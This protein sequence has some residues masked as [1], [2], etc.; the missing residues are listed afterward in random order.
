MAKTRFNKTHLSVLK[1]R[2]R[3]QTSLLI[4][5][6]GPPVDITIYVDISRNPGPN[7]LATNSNPKVASNVNLQ[8]NSTIK[9]YTRGELFKLRRASK[10]S[11]PIFVLARMKSANILR[12]WGKRANN[13]FFVSVGVEASHASKSLIELHNLSPPADTTKVPEIIEADKFQ[14]HLVSSHEIHRIIMSYSSNKAPGYDNITMSVIKDAL[15]CILPVLTDI[16][17]Q[18]LLSSAF[19]SDW[20]ISGFTPLLKEGDHE[21]AKNNCPV[22][23]LPVA[24]KVC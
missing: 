1:R 15:P 9:T 10:V 21:I 6:H 4:P 12:Y 2:K 19:P 7:S 18:S 11:I 8:V 5:G 3:G 17:N 16:V 24:S 13:N 14:F 23:L 22:S 20:K